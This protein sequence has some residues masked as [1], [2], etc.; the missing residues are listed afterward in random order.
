MNN[1]RM[2]KKCKINLL[3]FL[4]FIL[5]SLHLLMLSCQASLSDAY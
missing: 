4:C 3:A 5:T 1:V 2:G